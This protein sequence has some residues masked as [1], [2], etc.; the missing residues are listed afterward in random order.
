MI[1]GAVILAAALLLAAGGLGAVYVRVHR[2]SVAPLTGAW[3]LRVDHWTDLVEI[4][5]APGQVPGF[6]RPATSA[7]LPT[8]RE[9]LGPPP[10]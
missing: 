2:L 8:A 4:C 6:C 9:L 7:D 1:R 5:L 10:D 3:F